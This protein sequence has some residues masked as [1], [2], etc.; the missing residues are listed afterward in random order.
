M[1]LNFVYREIGWLWG[2]GSGGEEGVSGGGWEV[3]G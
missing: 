2:Y 1:C 3:G